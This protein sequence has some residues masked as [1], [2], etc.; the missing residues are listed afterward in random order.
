[1]SDLARLFSPEALVALREF[2]IETTAEISAPVDFSSPWLTMKDGAK[3]IH[4]S[5]RTFARLVDRGDIRTANVGR[6]RLVH[7]EELDAYLLGEAAREG[8]SPNEP[9]APRPQ[10]T[11]RSGREALE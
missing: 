3:R 7:R 11:S 2:V 8:K 10:R 9:T 1:V 5:P 6:R 4:V